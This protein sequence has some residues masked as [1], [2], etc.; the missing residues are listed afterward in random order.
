MPADTLS[1]IVV[2]IV[3]GRVVLQSIFPMGTSGY[4]GSVWYFKA[5]SAAS[6]QILA[7][8]HLLVPW[9]LVGK[10]GGLYVWDA[11]SALFTNGALI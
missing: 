9:L 5:V 6:S 3:E 8:C 7:P 1:R 10:L 2:T 4:A 11:P